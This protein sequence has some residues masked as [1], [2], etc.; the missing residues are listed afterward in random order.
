MFLRLNNNLVINLTSIRDVELMH[1]GKGVRVIYETTGNTPV[2]Y[3]DLT[4]REAESFR[5]WASTECTG[6]FPDRV[7]HIQATL[8]SRGMTQAASGGTQG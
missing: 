4:G 5:N 7:E 3:R 1:E 6:A 8:T 2:Q